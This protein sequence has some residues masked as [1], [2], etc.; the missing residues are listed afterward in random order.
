MAPSKTPGRRQDREPIAIIGSAC[1]FPGGSTSPTRLWDLLC[2][3]R[4][5]LCAIPSSRFNAK[6]FYHHYGD[7]HGAAN[8]EM[9]YLL[10]QG[11]EHCLF[12]AS[13]FNINSHEAEAMDPQQRLLL[14]TVYEGVESAGYA[15]EALQ[16]SDTAVFVGL[17][18][19]DYYD[20][21]MRDL[22]SVPKYLATGTA[23][24]II[25]N[26]ISYFFDW[27]GPS[28][29]IDTACSSSLVA[30]HQA[31]QSLRNGESSV[32]I[33]AGANLILGPE[34][35]VYESKL[36]MLS[37]TGRSRMWDASADGYARGEG[38]AAVVLKR[39]SKALE[40]GDHIESVI[41]ETGINQDGRTQ[42]ITMPNY[43][44]QA[45]LI[46]QTY[47]NA[48]L[49]LKVPSDRCQYFEAHGTGTLAGDPV[50]AEAVS[51]AFFGAEENASL[52]EVLYVGSVKTVI[53]HLEGT[54]GLAGLLRASLAVQHGLVPPNLLFNDLN[55]AIRPFYKNLK[56]PTVA[57]PWPNLPSGVPRRAS[58]NSFG[59]GG[60]N[61]HAIIESFDHLAA[62][63]PP[64]VTQANTISG[65]VRTSNYLPII[66]FTLSANS[67]ASLLEMMKAYSTYLK[68]NQSVDLRDLAWTLFQR[69]TV[70]PYRISLSDP[71]RER[72]CSRIDAEIPEMSS[73]RG[74]MVGTRITPGRTGSPRILG[75]FTGQG[76]QWP[77]MG[78][79]LIR[80]CSL[81]AD[82]ITRLDHFLSELHDAPSWTLMKE[83]QATGARS[84]I[85]EAA[86]SQPACTAVQTA[87]VDLIQAAGIKFSTVV[88]HSSG[89]IGAAYAAGLISSADAIRIAYYRGLHASLACGPDGEAGAML[90]AGYSYD[91][92]TIFCDQDQYEGRLAV[93]ASNGPK[94]VTLSGDLEAI[95]EAKEHLDG[96]GTFAR[97]LK[98]DIA[99]HSHHMEPCVEPYMASLLSCQISP[100]PPKDGCVWVSTVRDS[101]DISPETIQS[102]KDVYWK[103][104]M[105]SRVLFS[106]AIRRAVT[107]CGVFDIAL[108]I[109]PHS[110]LKGPATQTIKDVCNI[111][112]PYQGVMSRGEDDMQ[113]FSAA[114]GFIWV[115]LGPSA[116]D[117]DNYLGVFTKAI[118]PPK[119]LKGLPSYPWQHDMKFWK[120]SRISEKYR[121]RDD[122]IHELLGSRTPDEDDQELRWRNVLCLQE[123][124]WASGHRFQHQPLFPAAGYVSLA[125]EAAR[126]L[127]KGKAVRTI[128]LFDMK[129]LRAIT[130]EENSTG[131]ETLFVLRREQFG[132]DSEG[133]RQDIKARFTLSACTSGSGEMNTHFSGHVRIV[134][135]EPYAPSLP[136]RSECKPPMVNIDV[137]RFYESL[138]AIG[139]DYT[140]M[141]RGLTAIERRMDSARATVS[142]AISTSS[143][144]D[145]LV[146]PA[147]L[148]AS[149]Q[150]LFA[151]FCAP[152]D[153]SLWTTYLPTGIQKV[154]VVPALIRNDRENETGTSWVDSYVTQASSLSVVGD[155]EV[156]D[157]DGNMYIQ[158]EG[159]A[160]TSFSKPTPANDRNLFSKLVWKADI[161][162]G[163]DGV[164][165]NES[166]S[167]ENENEVAAVCERAS[168]FYLRNLREKISPE[169]DSSF[170]WHFQK[171][172]GFVDYVLP[173]IAN[174]SYKS[175]DAKWA[176]DSQE[177]IT[178]LVQK[179]PD[180]IDV[181]LVHA[182]GS[183]LVD[184]VRE[185]KETLEVMRERNMLDL[186]Y[187]EGIG[188]SRANERASSLASRITHKHT[189]MK[190]LEIGAGTGGTTR[191]V[192]G[193]IGHK[194]SMY[195]YTD[196]SAG[197][198]DKAQDIF[199]EH[200]NKMKFIKLDIERDTTAQGFE[201][202]S[203][204][205]IVASNVLHATR[206]L[207]NTMNNVRRLLRP[208]GYLL[209]MEITGCSLRNQFIMSGLPGWWL[210]VED[211]REYAPTISEAA[212]NSLLKS[213][214]FSGIDTLERDRAA[215]ADYSISVM[216]SQAVDERVYALR[217]PLDRLDLV[218]VSDRVVVVV[219]GTTP[220]TA[221]I[222]QAVQALLQPWNSRLEVVGCIE[223]LDTQVR[224]QK[225]SSM[226][227]LCLTD[228]DEPFF[229]QLSA[230]KLAALQNIFEKS[231]RVLWV[232]RNY[233]SGIPY[234]NIIVGLARTLQFEMPHLSLQLVDL[235]GRED[236]VAVT[237][238]AK[239]LTEA[240]LRI[241]MADLPE[242]MKNLLWT[243]EPELLFQGDRMMIPRIVANE[244][245]NDR[246]NSSR[247]LILTDIDPGKVP[248]K[249]FQE[250]DTKVWL[251]C[252][253]QSQRQLKLELAGSEAE[254]T[255]RVEY[256]L[257]HPVR[258]IADSYLFICLGD[259][260]STGERVVTFS[261]SNSSIITVPASWAT[262]CPGAVDGRASKYLRLFVWSLIAGSIVDA[263]SVPGTTIVHEP[264]ALLQKILSEQALEKGVK[265]LFVKTTHPVG[266]EDVIFFH[267]SVAERVI[268][269]Q[270]PKDLRTVFDMKCSN[271]SLSP[272]SRCAPFATFY[273][274]PWFFGR[275]SVLGLKALS[276][277]LHEIL[278][279]AS[280]QTDSLIHRGL[281]SLV[282][283]IIPLTSLPNI[284]T[285]KPGYNSILSWQTGKTVPIRVNPADPAMLFSRNKTYLLVGLTGELGRSLSLWMVMN[286]AKYIVLT[287][288][289]PQIPYDWLKEMEERGAVVS[290]SSL[291]IS[292]RTALHALHNEMR[293]KMPPVGGVANAAMVLSDKPF[294][295]MAMEQ[296]KKV[297]QPKV[298]GTRNLDELFSD[299]SLDF[300]ILFSSL[301][302]IVGNRGQSNYNAANMF[303][304]STARQRRERGLVASVMNIGMIIGLGYV[305]RTGTT[306]ERP[307]R[308]M[309]FMPISEREFHLIFT[310]A[311]IAGRSESVDDSEMIIGLQ[312][313]MDS[314]EIGDRPPWFSNP[315]FS[316]LVQTGAGASSAG[317]K[318]LKNA[319]AISV[320][321]SLKLVSSKSNAARILQDAFVARLGLMLQLHPNNMDVNTPLTGLGIDS[322]VAVDIRSWL[323]K[324]LKSAI[325]IF[326]IL[327]GITVAELC[328]E[329]VANLSEE[330][331]PACPKDSLVPTACLSK[332]EPPATQPL[333]PQLLT[334]RL[335]ERTSSDTRLSSSDTDSQMYNQW[336]SSQPTPES[337]SSAM[338]RSLSTAPKSPLTAIEPPPGLTA[339]TVDMPLE[340]TII[341]TM[342]MSTG[343][344]AL[345]FL[346][347]YLKDPATYNIAMRYTLRGPLDWRLFESALHT[348]IK[349][350][351]MLRTCFFRDPESKE[352][353]QGVL[354]KT[355]FKMQYKLIATDNEVQQEFN[356][357]R[358]TDFAL[359][360]GHTLDA[361]L[362]QRSPEVHDVIFSSHHIIMDGMSWRVFLADLHKAYISQHL[363][364]LR[365]QF[366]DFAEK[367]RQFVVSG[368]L[369][370]ELAYWKDVFRELPEPLPL[371]PISKVSC[372]HTMEV[373]NTRT[374]SIELDIDTAARVRHASK[375]LKATPFQFY[376]SALQALLYH[377][378]GTRD[379]CIGV[380]DANRSDEEFIETIG[381]FI[382]TLP[383]RFNFN[384]FESFNELVARTQDKI[385]SSMANSKLPFD[386][387]L[388]ELK[389]P[390]STSH[391]PLFQVLVNYRL[392]ALEQ[393]KL[394]DCDL[395]DAKGSVSMTP[396]DLTLL[397]LEA[398]KGECL[399]QFDVQQYLYSEDDTKQ[400]LRSY[401]HILDTFSRQPSLPLDQCKAFSQSAID[402][403]RHIGR[404]LPLEST[405]WQATL[406]H[407]IDDWIM[408][409]PGA[410]AILDG[411]GCE[412]SYESMGRKVID[413]ALVMKTSGI[414]AFSTVALLC[415]PSAIAI[416][417]MLA[418]LRMG[419]MCVPLDLSN[420][421]GRLRAILDEAQVHA[422]LYHNETAETMVELDVAKLTPVM[423]NVS[424]IC[425]EDTIIPNFAEADMPALTLYTSGT[426]GLPKGI[427]LS[428]LNIANCVSGI[429]ETLNLSKETVLQQSSFG[430]DLAIA[431]IFL[432]L[433]G[434]GKLIVAQRNQRGDA[435]KLSK[436][437]LRES[438]SFTFCV[439]SE[440]SILLRY[441][442]ETLKQ[443]VSW[444]LAISAG[445]RLTSRI[446]QQFQRLQGNVSLINAYG[447]AETTIISHLGKVTYGDDNGGEVFESVGQ[448]LPNFS[449]YILDEGG[450]P[451]PIGF[452]GEIYIGG[453]SVSSGYSNNKELT[454]KKFLPNPFATSD[455]IKLGWDRIYRSGDKGRL[456][457]DGS[458]VPLGRIQ[459]DNQIKLRGMRVELEGVEHAILTTA[460]G[461]LGDVVVITK[462]ENDLAFLVGFVTFAGGKTPSRTDNFLRTLIEQLPLPHYMRPTILV[463]SERLPQTANG[464]V[465]RIALGK[466]TVARQDERRE[467][468]TKPLSPSEAMLANIWRELLHEDES[469]PLKIYKD[470]DFFDVGGNSLL[471]VELQSAV[472]QAFGVTFSLRDFFHSSSIQNMV[473]RITSSGAT[474]KR[475]MGQVIEWSQ[476]I[477]I[478][479]DLYELEAVSS[480]IRHSATPATGKKVLLTGA[481]GF[482]GSTLLRLLV[483]DPS[484][485]QV[486][487]VAIRQQPGSPP[488]APPTQSPKITL[489][490]GDLAQPRLGLSDSDFYMLSRDID[491]IIHNG[492]EVSFLKSYQSLSQVN[493]SSTR[494]L[495]KL[496]YPR[497]I[498]IHYVSTGGIACLL[499]SNATSGAATVL[500]ETPLP[501]I[502][503]PPIDGSDGYT[504]TKWASERILEAA[505]AE[506]GAR[507][508][509]HRPTYI[510]GDG[511]PATDLVG[512]ILRYSREMRAV[513]D[514]RHWQGC[515][516]LVS[517]E[518]VARD[519]LG[520]ISGDSESRR[521]G[522]TVF[523]RHHCGEA[524]I[525]VDGLKAH[526]DQ[527]LGCE[528]RVLKLSE[529]IEAAEK[530]GLAALMVSFLRSIVEQEV[531]LPE[532][533]KAVR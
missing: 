100:C 13:F 199:R 510:V 312:E 252:Q 220:R 232:T 282:D 324:E 378:T 464:K 380:V 59:F 243:N 314:V 211:G 40:D 353:V 441:G 300:F 515:F 238:T 264:D 469:T 284:D 109:G 263:G 363:P 116:I 352:A 34:M 429:T 205:L 530:A 341:R 198:F 70:F 331:L 348:V 374:V 518:S 43:S 492:A 132:S 368:S 322:L 462:G 256:S 305:S 330:M 249:V 156:F 179:Y 466:I 213:T 233:R 408:K 269:R 240:M 231:K 488:R 130:L 201:D 163:C 241:A 494:E 67:K 42:G 508:W 164:D 509:I 270:L 277:S 507:A 139:L 482:L 303:L 257:M 409:S 157:R 28:M 39:L 293:T 463:P 188:F 522:E 496:S 440:Y 244:E 525:P 424:D 529:W 383:V 417:S 260:I 246:L 504:A 502:V 533:R 411:Y 501:A 386:V 250:K 512:T 58:V 222:I 57:T 513:P 78:S 134:L 111:D 345:W 289:N 485:S 64:G 202:N 11:D 320:A 477:A 221:K 141:F 335:L 253:S 49:D 279:S 395:T 235:E 154:R 129:I 152:G 295:D 306:Y 38:F 89:E 159:L 173:A 413:I 195:H 93:A 336:T 229:E 465:D 275:E 168:Y 80:S 302:S 416:C 94:S 434:G 346:R 212:W 215:P 309:N 287:S 191:S 181:Q 4:D 333:A 189:H 479:P 41:R 285:T 55:P 267:H 448:S 311:I 166:L 319:V 388:E 366:I 328:K 343:Q 1:R 14:E 52:D 36:H 12:D 197:F 354:G 402:G 200:A 170:K 384:E 428:H 387:L 226:S 359:E 299:N 290:V 281:P 25:S 442:F 490:A 527:E 286:G 46:R 425:D 423:I 323:L 149:L 523:I 301:A 389:V 56:V 358:S 435:I 471:I 71:D 147:L 364:P 138:L 375:R 475:P 108:E 357:L 288:R 326:K 37:P 419:A 187:T 315:R 50:E 307:L 151:G 446:K 455:D 31:V 248:V 72:L 112:V 65:E 390:R 399:L 176:N 167:E 276:E 131:I 115:N 457:A 262:K 19:G 454:L 73:A 420:P 123:L 5:L 91:Q 329:T 498:P 6:A 186:L 450:A 193:G 75:I 119:L 214:G 218:P 66:P 76:A 150:T 351:E 216:V 503:T 317:G 27:K 310:E 68:S 137:D 467:A 92:A 451:V 439:P 361:L 373:Y 117:L 77:A 196:I 418:V 381:Y 292:D 444:R 447:P 528:C 174:G 531:Q 486:H 404:G 237:Q 294:V 33:A 334:P 274:A 113:A 254:L 476:E 87:L 185:R 98:V 385:Y 427:I 47:A 367:E 101:S 511:S 26:R 255:I 22:N 106:Q 180:A 127:A 146:H 60:T 83:L 97:V 225:F 81:F 79:S 114:I 516:D 456:L 148:D 412:L 458:L 365:H 258:V 460:K 206:I 421:V 313:T 489:Y 223:D 459:G 23:R 162:S 120:E 298:A 370:S 422:V 3:P 344:S 84:R 53:G 105:T 393:T 122:P 338:S 125:I 491:A 207:K 104:N 15:I 7:Y 74:G 347:R 493:V 391:S 304:I 426:T 124:P 278:Q 24:S 183:N 372:R 362:I 487:C 54:A 443:C 445:E 153:G 360:R 356:R 210:G 85:N 524:R 332:P 499:N 103:D 268:Q 296:M 339:M 468:E 230:G 401:I 431:Q 203:Y 110:A 470:T 403:S 228:L 126:I 204:D 474:Y 135:G 272:I 86:I 95:E 171:L 118:A 532:V 500:Y 349:R 99:Y 407:Q 405:G 453:P 484:V 432:A 297:F 514:L 29:T 208:G 90:A 340:M 481:F 128:E 355:P 63:I 452:P 140:G 247:R 433:G 506:F 62:G 155:V 144:G 392:G 102:M 239:Q 44:S 217:Q 397:V 291:D 410:I 478:D 184:I 107:E 194:F 169:E 519:I 245:L 273:P 316:H 394:G 400:L 35:Y 219:G 160:C 369:K 10:S 8:V 495:L 21:Q 121:L 18:T 398:S 136:Q 17:M 480:A 337:Q 379:L 526:F 473:D 283:D 2:S 165:S 517:V 280:K 376:L 265:I 227:I 161:L 242:L 414:K 350:H 234:G 82:S 61:A 51:K 45:S 437:M 342:R 325:P 69:R 259:V 251:A 175:V 436:L 30:V 521:R 271:A 371:L 133:E 483:N 266:D 321:E 415:E 88:G 9:S 461:I 96:E 406:L 430:F 308:K 177:L 261:V 377:F 396:Y 145:L 327:S 438:I 318:N 158:I 520:E 48:G 172:L 178:F 236:D 16:G 182:V 209:L 472:R 32:A 143:S 224:D 505:S 497:R 142:K 190:I 20:I 449:T 382:N 192:L